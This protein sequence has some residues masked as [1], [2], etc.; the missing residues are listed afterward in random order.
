MH[1]RGLLHEAAQLAV[2]LRHMKEIQQLESVGSSCTFGES[3]HKRQATLKIRIL[4]AR[5]EILGRSLNAR[6][7]CALEQMIY[8]AK[9]AGYDGGVCKP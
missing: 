1:L 8:F 2:S 7:D 6:D 9:L 3:T 5:A 4:S